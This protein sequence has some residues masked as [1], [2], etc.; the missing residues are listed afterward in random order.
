M[1]TVKGNYCLSG[2]F[3]Q[4]GTRNERKDI[5]TGIQ[6]HYILRSILLPPSVAAMELK[7]SAFFY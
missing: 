2:S 1:I 7:L 3:G 6:I 5:V 4:E